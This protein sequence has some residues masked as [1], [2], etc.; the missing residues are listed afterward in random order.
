MFKMIK[1]KIVAWIDAKKDRIAESVLEKKGLVAV[2][3]K[4]VS[5]SNYILC[6]DGSMERIGGKRR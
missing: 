6:D 1:E 3:I 4:S 5:G 2:R